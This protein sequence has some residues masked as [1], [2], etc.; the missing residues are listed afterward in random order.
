MRE[1]ELRADRD[2]LDDFVQRPKAKGKN[3]LA[4]QIALGIIIGGTVLMA[5]EAL[6]SLLMAKAV[7][8]SLHL[9]FN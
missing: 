2:P 6:G 3:W 4:Y 8:S 5:I 7:L 1:D 9:N